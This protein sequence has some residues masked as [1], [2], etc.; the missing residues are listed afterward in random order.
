MKNKYPIFIPTK[1]RYKPFG[2]TITMFQKHNVDF[3]IVIEPQEIEEYSKIVDQSKIIVT[4]H[5]DQGLTVT[6]NWIWDYAEEQ[7]Y[8]KFW[9]FDDNIGRVYRWNKNSRYQC[10][11]GMYIRIVE[12]FSDRYK[13]LPIIGMNYM[14]FCKSTDPIPPYYPNTRVYSNM[15]L[16]TNA[17]LS[18]G[19]KLRNKL[20]YNDD[21]DLCLRVLKDNQ[22]TIQIN[23]FLI[24]KA[25]TMTVQGGMTD[26]YESEA[27]KGRLV[28]AEEL[29]D[30]HP[31]VTKVTQKF[32]R[33]HHHVN[34]KPF[35]ENKLIK[36]EDVV[37]EDKVNEYGMSLIVQNTRGNELEKV[38][39]SL[40]KQDTRAIA[41][42]WWGKLP[43]F[44]KIIYASQYSIKTNISKSYNSLS[45]ADIEKIYTLIV[46]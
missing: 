18:N 32:N 36:K 40:P 26:Y 29:R 38:E 21:T 11:D 34:Y 6:R 7:G 16:D 14:G 23:A 2:G 45:D 31:D 12:D 19:E 13:N 46:K 20:F 28:F 35:R 27:C 25:A 9:T 1:G 30:A 24:D 39:Q 41:L 15:L 22:C 8:E 5:R 10:K 44:K 37:I 33:W 42:D 3:K 4:P 43:T 17:R